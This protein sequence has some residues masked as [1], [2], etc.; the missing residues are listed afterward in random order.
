MDLLSEDEIVPADILDNKKTENLVIRYDY[1]R[2]PNALLKVDANAFQSTKNYTKNVRFMNFKSSQLDLGFLSGFNQLTHLSFD[3]VFDILKGLSTLPLLPKLAELRLDHVRGLDDLM[4]FPTLLSNGL[5]NFH[6]IYY[7]GKEADALVSRMLDWILTYS[8]KTLE[9]LEIREIRITEIPSQVPSFTALRHLD[10]SSNSISTVK[11]GTLSFTVPVSHLEITKNKI[12]S[13]E[14]A[15]FQGIY[16][17]IY[18]F[19]FGYFFYP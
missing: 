7:D 18:C 1:I 10:L 11:N 3:G 6:L 13:I 9:V 12:N 19:T 14:P 5:K 2:H 17:F 15:A 16:S 4:T 8:A